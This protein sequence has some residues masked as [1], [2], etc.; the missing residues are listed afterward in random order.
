MILIILDTI[1]IIAGL[2]IL[3]IIIG[4]IIVGAA[5]EAYRKREHYKEF[6]L[7]VFIAALGTYA[8]IRVCDIIMA[9]AFSVGYLGLNP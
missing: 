6:L 9:Y 4:V 8:I 7:F 2:A 3:S 5:K 1:F